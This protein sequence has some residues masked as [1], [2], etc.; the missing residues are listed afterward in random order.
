MEAEKKKIRKEM[1]AKLKEL[2]KPEHEQRSYEIARR[3][4]QNPL[5]LDARTIA[6]TVSNPPEPETWQIIRKAWE[7]GRRVAVPKCIPK[8]KQMVFRKLERFSELESVYYGLWE[9]IEA[10]T[11]EVPGEEI[12]TMIVPGL[13][14][15]K[16]GY[17]LGFGGGYYDRFLENY[18]GKTLSLA[19]SFQV[20]ETLPVEEHDRPVDV[21]IT[22]KQV[23]KTNDA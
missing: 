22:D 20:I 11:K 5:W 1:L 6:I 4:Y 12:D 17:R 13:A 21:I 23:W 9:P 10:S 2:Q 3:L 15:L 19:F 16:N 7:E 8:T 14:Y 18:K